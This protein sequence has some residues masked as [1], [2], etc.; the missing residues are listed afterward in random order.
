MT[1]GDRNV[2]GAGM[3]TAGWGGDL[4]DSKQLNAA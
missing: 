2:I 3:K 1:L 4:S